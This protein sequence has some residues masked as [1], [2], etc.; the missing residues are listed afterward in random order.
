[1]D[2]ED[3]DEDEDEFED[4]K[5]KSKEPSL[6]CPGGIKGTGHETPFPESIDLS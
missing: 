5:R 4:D 6:T 1:V 2:Q 3:E